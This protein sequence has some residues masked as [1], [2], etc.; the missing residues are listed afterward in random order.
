M[1][2]RNI[3]F[4]F[5]TRPELIKI[6][7]LVQACKKEFNVKV[8]STGQHRELLNNLLHWFSIEPEVNLDIMKSNQSP[9]KVIATILSHLEAILV[10][11]DLVIVQGDTASAYAGAMS[12]FLHQI[13]VAHLEA[14]L[15]T[16]NRYNPFPEEIFRRQITQVADIHFAPTEQSAKNIR[17]EGFEENVYVVGNTVIDSLKQTTQRLLEIE[18]S[19]KIGQKNI[20]KNELSKFVDLPFRKE[21][22]GKR[23]LL[24]TMHRRENLGQDHEQVASALREI[25][26]EFKDTAIV[27]PI[28][29]NPMVRK[30][31]EPLLENQ[32]RVHLIQPIDYIT[33]A[34]LLQK[35]HILIT[36]SG[37]LQEEG[38]SIGKPT[39]V[40]RETTERPEAVEAGVAKLV[41]T[42]KENV[43]NELR[44]L[45]A[46]QAAYDKMAKPSSVYGDGKT[47]EKI[48][49]I[50][51]NYFS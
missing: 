32:P 50:L 27:F 6:A 4:I 47:S 20:L 45:L 24:V 14:G 40:L 2:K 7:P 11:S 36:D 25:V 18:Q 30:A 42:N 19:H 41:G 51:K 17:K 3:S 33:L 5:G 21:L 22:E 26:E 39:L 43:K 12:A 29:P 28:H 23:I 49:E 9:S 16:N 31:V 34:W 46:D 35:T 48:V 1:K 8:I 38:A 15:R 13:P 37:G 10:G 44:L